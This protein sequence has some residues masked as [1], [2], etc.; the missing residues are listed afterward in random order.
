MIKE[1]AKAKGFQRLLGAVLNEASW[2]GSMQM[3][4]FL[5]AAREAYRENLIDVG[6]LVNVL[7]EVSASLLRAKDDDIKND[8]SGSVSDLIKRVQYG[9]R[10]AQ[11]P[12]EDYYKFWLQHTL[13]LMG[14][15]PLVLRLFA[16]EQIAA[17]IETAEWHKPVAMRY[18]V[19]GAGCEAVN[20]TYEFLR[21]QEDKDKHWSIIY[22][23]KGNDALSPPMP[24]L[25]LIRCKMK[26]DCKKWFFS[27]VEDIN[28]PGTNSDIDYYNQGKAVP[29]HQKY[30][31]REP[32][33]QPYS[34]EVSKNK[35]SWTTLQPPR[36]PHCARRVSTSPRESRWRCL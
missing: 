3:M 4:N 31:E 2:H 22:Q 19:E 25:T 28:N 26:D 11:Q 14:S 12:M 33:S 34:W 13:K 6:L 9:Y 23:K 24:T 29:S 35:R 7:H 10:T 20:G 27:E 36:V 21:K 32:P 1:F 5:E 8:D 18:I 17:I 15:E 30:L 16:W